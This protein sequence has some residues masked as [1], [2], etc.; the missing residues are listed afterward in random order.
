MS[1][2]SVLKLLNKKCG[3]TFCFRFQIPGLATSVPPKLFPQ[4]LLWISNDVH[5][6]PEGFK[7]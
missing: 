3:L 4:R 1:E 5:D 2:E 7:K 6:F